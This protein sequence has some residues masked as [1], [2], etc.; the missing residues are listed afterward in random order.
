MKPLPHGL[1]EQLINTHL[2]GKLQGQNINK[3]SLKNFDSPVVL[4][5][6]L[7]PVL[8]RSLEFLEESSAADQIACCNDIIRLLAAITKEECLGQCVIPDD[9]QVLLSVGDSGVRPVTPLAQSSLF[10]GSALEPSLIQ[11]LKAEILSTDRIDIK[12]F[13]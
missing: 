12:F 3:D 11:E 8:R 5:Q 9:G 7:A 4:T 6:Y 1:Y 10:T 2:E 13:Q